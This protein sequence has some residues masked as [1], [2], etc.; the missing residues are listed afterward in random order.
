MPFCPLASDSEA[1]CRAFE[2]Y[3]RTSQKLALTIQFFTEQLPAHLK[4]IVP[5]AGKPI[6]VLG[7]G[8]GSGAKDIVLF[9]QLL[10]S[11]P[12]HNI[13]VDIY[14]PGKELTD[15]FRKAFDDAAFEPRITINFHLKTSQECRKE[16]SVEDK[17]DLIYALESL[18]YEESI[19]TALTDYTGRLTPSG[20]FIVSVTTSNSGFHQVAKIYS[21]DGQKADELIGSDDVRKAMSKEL[22]AT[23]EEFEL[24][25]AFDVSPIY[26]KGE[27]KEEVEQAYAMIEFVSHIA[28][29]KAVASSQE[30]ETFKERVRQKDV[31]DISSDG[32]VL[33]KMPFTFFLIRK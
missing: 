26:G 17:Y 18:Y 8:S 1:Y 3:R 28:N 5:E 25:N 13:A 30:F 16:R 22:G 29:F 24:P 4:K 27:D 7:V 23:F 15:L 33:L 6:R 11:F 19:A 2:A 9:K 21:T 32:R 12:G 20:L 31:S 14:E 10:T